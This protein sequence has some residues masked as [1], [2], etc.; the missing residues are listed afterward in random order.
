MT[1]PPRF[2]EEHEQRNYLGWILTLILVLLTSGYASYYYTTVGSEQY[3]KAQVVD[4][5][6]REAVLS[7]KST[8][9]VKWRIFDRKLEALKKTDIKRY[10]LLRTVSSYERTKTVDQQDI[11]RLRAST[12]LAHKAVADIYTKSFTKL[13]MDRLEGKI[14]KDLFT[15]V[16]ADIHLHE[17]NGDSAYRAT[18]MPKESVSKGL[19]WGQII[20]L[21]TSCLL[22]MLLLGLYIGMRAAGFLKPLGHPLQHIGLFDSDRLALR[23]AQIMAGMTAIGIL[24]SYIGFLD[25]DWMSIV[26]ATLIIGFTLLIALTPI[27][28]R[29][30]ALA[31]IGLSS[32]NLL[33]NIGWGVGAFFANIPILIGVTILSNGLFSSMPEVSHPIVNE[34]KNASNYAVWIAIFM[35][36]SVQAPIVEEILFRGTLL[37]AMARVFRSPMLGIVLSSLVF[38]MG[39]STGLPSWLPLA[40]IGAMAA[41]L[42]FQTR[43]L[44]PAMVLHA[45]HNGSMLL[46]TIFFS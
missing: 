46:I 24:T 12:N 11:K 36:A 26:E 31:D 16:M 34:I 43:S 22:G 38:A 4:K 2:D 39:H 6:F 25:R 30:F 40:S 29:R 8:Q 42:T 10:S 21:V 35:S 32:K 28:G 19:N 13:E 45:V 23:A 18:H 37:P 17:R 41:G 15:G 44:V 5:A 9:T 20:V 33:K 1:V 7:R 27:W 3:R 14:S